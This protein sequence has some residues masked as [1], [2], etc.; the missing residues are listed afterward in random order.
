M[1]MQS[2]EFY[3]S[4]LNRVSRS[5]AFCIQ[6]LESPLRQWVSLSYLLCRVLDTVEDSQW[7]SIALRSGQYEEFESFMHVNPSRSVVAEWSS[8]FPDSIPEGEKDLLADAHLLFQDLHDLPKSV[9]KHLQ[10]TVLRMSAGMRHY[11]QD[12]TGKLKLSDLG[13]V[14]RYCYFV[15]GIVGELLTHLVLEAWPEFKP[16][17]DIFRNAFHFGLF[18]QKVN[19]LKD[20][21]TDEKEGRYLVPSRQLLL[22]SLRENA[23]GAVD[24]IVS[25]PTEEKGF[26]VFCAWSLFLGAASLPFIQQAF[27]HADGSK[28]PRSVTEELLEAIEEI[29]QDNEALQ[30][31]LLPHLDNLP[32]LESS[33][34]EK[35]SSANNPENV[36]WFH[37]I[38]GDALQAQDF[39]SLRLV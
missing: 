26:R 35:A 25:L 19:L 34:F 2:V 5:F 33:T 3:Q 7:S 13:E 11:G 36:D 17:D 31:E 22:A 37:R 23:Q 10:D 1:S 39:V 28:I 14:N 20:Q 8:R 32:E 21:L 4:H 29:C 9:R 16:R 18:L 38:A 12:P 30:S 27:S 24:Y 15:A 6:K